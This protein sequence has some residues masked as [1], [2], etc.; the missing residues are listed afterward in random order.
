MKGVLVYAF[1]NDVIDYFKQATWCADRVVRYLGLPV[2]IV[3][4]E[5]SLAQRS[6]SHNVVFDSP[7]LGGNRIYD[8]RKNNQPNQWFNVNRI[9]SYDLSP[10]DQTV[11]LD[12]DYVVCGDRLNLL[13]D[14]PFDVT[15]MKYAYDVT[16]RDQL[17]SYQFISTPR[18]L[19]HFWATVM[20]FRKVPIAQDFFQLLRMINNNYKHYARQYKMH[21]KPYRNDHAVSIALNTLYGHMEQNIPTIPWKMANALGDVDIQQLDHN[22]FDLTY[23][24]SSR[25]YRVRLAG[26]DFHFMN[27]ISLTKL[28]E[29]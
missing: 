19:H 27:K 14:S 4:D 11:V 16:G 18:G 8:R 24:K 10:Y 12:S 26:E 25:Q 23:D 6:C 22:V 2:T 5:A 20:Y 15:A 21:T 17:S 29:N 28:Y 3:T 9:H 13:F 7:I 1:N